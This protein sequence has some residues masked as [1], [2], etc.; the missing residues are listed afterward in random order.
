MSAL[1]IAWAL[2]NSAVDVAIVGARSPGHIEDSL[3]A[4]E[5]ELSEGELREIDAI[6]A[7]SVPVAGP[8]PE[9]V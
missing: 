9:G 8:T 7:G 6:M 2:A 3:G 4:V 1:A 5:L